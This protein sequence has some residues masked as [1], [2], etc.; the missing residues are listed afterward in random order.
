MVT[1][2]RSPLHG[3]P[4]V[5]GLDK[6]RR[7]FEI[8]IKTSR[9]DFDRDAKKPHRAK[10]LERL[11]RYRPQEHNYLAYLVPLE[12][13]EHVTEH[14]P[15]YAGI[16]TVNAAQLSPYTGF[17]TIQVIRAPVRLHDNR[18]SMRHCAIMARDMSGTM[19]S[20]LR[21]DV[22]EHMRRDELEAQ[23][24]VLGGELPTFSRKKKVALPGSDVKA[25]GAT[26]RSK[27]D[28]K[29]VRAGVKKSAK[30]KAGKTVRSRSKKDSPNDELRA[31]LNAPDYTPTVQLRSKA[32]KTADSGGAVG[33]ADIVH[34]TPKRK[35]NFGSAKTKR[36]T[37]KIE[38]A[39][40]ARERKNKLEA[41]AISKRTA[42]ARAKAK[43]KK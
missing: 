12:L 23:V 16:F 7:L 41:I 19:A 26:R 30:L 6:H 2:E 29:K 43:A 20:L 34:D 5:L 31:V 33:W 18:L 22:K 17:P 11:N 1:F 36:R 27:S 8:E 28:E 25:T 13:V 38:R 9:A 35:A 14:A 39:V 42:E 15:S 24:V 32:A 21:D 4:D 3:K 10:L 37:K 40:S